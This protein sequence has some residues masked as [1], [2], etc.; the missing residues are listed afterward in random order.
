MKALT[1]HGKGD[2]R[3]ETVPDPKTEHQRDAIIKIAACAICG[4]DLL[5]FDGVIPEMKT[6]DVVSGWMNKMRT[7]MA[8]V[9]LPACWRKCMATWRSR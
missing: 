2:M 9:T 8:N 5:I 7:A 3:C 1:F 6:C 4:S